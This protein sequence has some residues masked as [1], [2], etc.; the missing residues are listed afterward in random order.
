M[1]FNTQETGGAMT[2]G[3]TIPLSGHAEP[4]AAAALVENWP[5]PTPETL[6]ALAAL[7]D[8]TPADVAA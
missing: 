5:P 4:S 1:T 7:I 2:D 6:A 3:D 8:V